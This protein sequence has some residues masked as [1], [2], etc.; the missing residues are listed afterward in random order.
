MN[1]HET[2]LPSC[3]T[4]VGDMSDAGCE[5]WL[6]NAALWHD[7]AAIREIVALGVDV[8]VCGE[9]GN[10]ALISLV[11]QPPEPGDDADAIMLAHLERF[12]ENP[13]YRSTP[14]EIET[15]R[16]LL[17]H[18]LRLDLTDAAG[19]TALACAAYG[20]NRPAAE[21]LLAVGADCLDFGKNSLSPFDIAVREDRHELLTL[22]LERTRSEGRLVA[23]DAEP[24]HGRWIDEATGETARML[25]AAFG[26]SGKEARAKVRVLQDACELE[27]EAPVPVELYFNA[28][29]TAVFWRGAILKLCPRCGYV[30][31]NFFDYDGSRYGLV[32]NYQCPRCLT[33]YILHDND[34]GGSPIHY[35]IHGPGGYE[36]LMSLDYT[37]LYRLDALGAIAACYAP[38]LYNDLR[39]RSRV[40]LGDIMERLS[41]VL[42]TPTPPEAGNLLLEGGHI[43]P[44]DVAVWL[45]W[46]ERLLPGET[47]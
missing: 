28:D 39:D 36:T 34:C 44:P 42:P 22:F 13:T 40:T 16:L 2:R 11:L 29:G 26:R 19:S 20:D 23:I 27:G 10:S 7:C 46:V 21:F 38:G 6:L 5:R 4:G 31:R 14:E 9:G 25:E 8:N 47:P 35:V 45:G 37:R 17:S 15:M 30:F 43:P 32:G 41:C 18:G 3:H 1:N 24:H 33:W 12:V